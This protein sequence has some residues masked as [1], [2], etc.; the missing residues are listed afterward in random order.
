MLKKIK[1]HSMIPVLWIR[2]KL[3]RI[4][5]PDHNWHPR[6]SNMCNTLG[7]SRIQ[8]LNWIC[9]KMESCIRIQIGN[10]NLHHC[11]MLSCF[12][13]QTINTA[14]TKKLV[15]SLILIKNKMVDFETKKDGL[16]AIKPHKFCQRD[17]SAAVFGFT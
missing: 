12:S 16:S 15:T 10:T 2:T 8:I 14:E 11:I 6:F 4:T 17:C 7:R 9:N 5:L 3:N 1:D 13:L